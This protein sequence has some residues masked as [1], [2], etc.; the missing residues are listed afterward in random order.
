MNI[1]VSDTK[2][3]GVPILPKRTNTREVVPVR[4]TA[5]GTSIIAAIRRDDLYLLGFCSVEDIW[6]ACRL[7]DT[8]AEA[9]DGKG[10]QKGKSTEFEIPF[11]KGAI[12]MHFFGSYNG[13]LGQ[14]MNNFKFSLQS[15]KSSIKILGNIKRTDVLDEKKAQL[16]ES[17]A[18]ICLFIPECCRF[19]VTGDLFI[20]LADNP[21]HELAIVDFVDE[22]RHWGKYSY[23]VQ[24]G[25]DAEAAEKTPR[26]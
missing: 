23:P 4:L 3:R 16:V 17:F 19:L 10:K 14:K 26:L 6:F 2:A 25:S 15:F 22:L 5:F 12:Q 1:V 20:G 18:R 24:H 13:M 21:Y 11:I 7:A 9:K 8:P